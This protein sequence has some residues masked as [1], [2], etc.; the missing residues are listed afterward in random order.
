[1]Q[2]NLQFERLCQTLQLGEITGVPEAMSGGL[3][4][5]MYTVETTQGKYAV[6]AIN[7][8]IMLRPLAKQ[9]YIRSERIANL[10]AN[11]IS[12]IPAIKLN[13]SY[14][15]EIEGQSYLVFH[16]IDGKTLKPDEITK[17]HCAEIGTILAKIHMMDF[18]ELDIVNDY[19]NLD[20]ATL[21]DWNYY[22]QKGHELNAAW[23]TS[24]LGIIDKLFEW[25]AKANQAVRLLAADRVISHGDLDPKNVLWSQG[26]PVVIDWESVGYINPM[27]DLI[28]TAIYWSEDD[29]GNM[30]QERFETF[31]NAYKERY[32]KLQADWKTVL[33]NGFLGKLGWLEY[34]FKRSLG[35]ECTSEEEQQLGTVQA[36]GTINAIKRYAD[37]IP[38]LEL[39]LNKCS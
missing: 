16:W 12:A 27:Q 29:M 14:L 24:L 28:E 19:S 31:I 7:P 10:A 22:L 25:N 26:H 1:M 21:I 32:G 4:H 2:Y 39:Q 3:L 20:H 38:E 23:V 5:K 11:K 35:M 8:Q 6:K 30:E 33:E 37:N 9:S 36:T 18:S 13:D 34:S 17:V 15:H